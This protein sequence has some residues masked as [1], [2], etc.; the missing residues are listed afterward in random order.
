MTTTTIWKPIPKS[1]VPQCWAYNLQWIRCRSN[2]YKLR[3]D[4]T[5]SI[6][7]QKEQLD[8]YLNSY[9]LHKESRVLYKEVKSYYA[10][11][12]E[13]NIYKAFDIFYN[14]EDFESFVNNRKD[15]FFCSSYDLSKEE[16]QNFLL[17]DKSIITIGDCKR[18]GNL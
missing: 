9:H 17:K 8:L 15:L 7:F 3:E 4:E 14:L 1:L 5:Y 11:E 13:G 10:V 16:I 6:S 2:L 18:Y 12:I